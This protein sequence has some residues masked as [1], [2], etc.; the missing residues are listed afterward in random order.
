MDTF[1]AGLK[2]A[3]LW[4]AGAAVAV[5]GILLVILKLRPAPAPAQPT[6]PPVSSGTAQNVGTAERT[7]AGQIGA[8]TATAQAGKTE[9]NN[10]GKLT[11]EQERLKR[12]AEIARN[13]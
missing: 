5:G 10:A 9:L 12:L 4:I 13:S 7:A 2:K 11:D 6:L 8:A 1:L 3:A